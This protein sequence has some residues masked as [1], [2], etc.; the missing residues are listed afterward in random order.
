MK[1]I[2]AD[3]D[4]RI[5]IEGVRYPVRQPV[6]IDKS[7]T[8]F[9]TLRSLRIYRF[10]ADSVVDGHAEEDE[11]LIVLLEGTVELTLIGDNSASVPRPV[12]VSAASDAPGHPC[13]AYLPPHAAY[14][15][16]ARTDADVAYARA[17]PADGPAP[18]IFPSHAG[19]DHDGVAH[20][21]QEASYPRLLR[22]RLIQIKAGQHEIAIK[23]IEE[24]DGPCEALIHVR[25]FPEG[26]VTAIAESGAIT[27]PLTS[28]NLTWSDLTS[29]DLKSWDTV[30]VP[31]GGYPA[32]RIAA[33]SSALVLIV[34][35]T[36]RLPYKS[37]SLRRV[38]RSRSNSPST[39]PA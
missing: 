32:L 30:A 20:L 1:L 15:L 19:P 24:P 34:L 7:Q 21:L 8:G 38:G 37:P 9:T 36:R 18:C 12:T 31:P 13:A 6:S 11:V 39:R 16:I 25:S 2:Q 23:P 35:A 14:R 28:W 27:S 29:R 33:E 22:V 17:T 3:H 4:R 26:Q 10:E 5:T